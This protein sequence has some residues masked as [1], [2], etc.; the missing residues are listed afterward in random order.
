MNERAMNER[1]TPEL[2]VVRGSATGEE[3]AAVVTVLMARLAARERERAARPRGPAQRRSAWR[4]R[5]SLMR[6]P[7]TPGPGAWRA[8][9]LPR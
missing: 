1:D 4:D 2:R 9:A 6:D 8:S 3:A 7:V 5:S